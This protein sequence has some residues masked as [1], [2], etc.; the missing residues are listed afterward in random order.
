MPSKENHMAL[1]TAPVGDE[2][3]IFLTTNTDSE[4]YPRMFGL[5]VLQNAINLMGSN[6]TLDFNKEHKAISMSR[7][8]IPTSDEMS[9][10][11]TVL[12]IVPSCSD[13]TFISRALVLATMEYAGARTA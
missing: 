12:D 8:R 4:E 3:Y 2:L 6:L 5:E 9:W 7:K 1:K 10:R 11:L 13:N